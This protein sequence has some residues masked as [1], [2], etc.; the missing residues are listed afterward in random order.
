LFCL[1]LGQVALCLAERLIARG[2]SVAGT[3]RSEAK[4]AEFARRGIRA[5]VAA[6]E[7]PPADPDAALAGATHLLSSIAPDTEGDAG[8]DL[9]R[10]AIGR[11]PGWRWIG[12]LSA[13][14]VYGDR[15]GGWVD[16]A[17]PP[18]P[19]GDRGRNRLAAERRW[20]ALA[21]PAHVFRLAGIYGPGSNALA[22]VRSGRAQRVVKP[23]LAFSRIHVEDIATVLEASMAR[24]EPGTV[25]NVADDEPAPPDAVIAYAC[26]LLGVEPP[27]LIPFE[28]AE[29]SP[30]ARSF[31]ADDKR[32]SNRRIK[33]ALGVTL[34][35]PTYREGLAALLPAYR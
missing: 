23:G 18:Q 9:W 16:E 10:A 30:M 2:W 6:R 24:P 4:A 13:T 11:H 35:Y 34:R 21:P 19:N 5:I 28:T 26:D 29:L 7:T 3:T 1:G 15:Q 12:Y 22:T 33:E 20:Q 27:P 25:Y 8:L 17:T 14:S 31:Y 32:V